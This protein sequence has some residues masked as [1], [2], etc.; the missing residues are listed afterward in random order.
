MFTGFGAFVE[1][2]EY[3][4]GVLLKKFIVERSN[5]YNTQ[6]KAVV[7]G[8]VHYSF[9][10]PWESMSIHFVKGKGSRA[11]DM[12]NNEYLD[13]FGKFGANILGY[14]N[15]RYVESLVSHLNKITAANL[16]D[17]DYGAAQA[18]CDAVPGAE[19]VR[20]SLSGT[21]AVQN[22]IRLARG[23]TKKN[24]F[25]RFSPHFHGNADNIMGGA[26]GD[27]SDPTP[28]TFQNDLYDTE[29]KAEG[30]LQAQSFLLPWNDLELLKEVLHTN[31]DVVAAIITEP[32]CINGG[33]IM[34]L[35]GYLE[36]MR[37]LCDKYGI[38]LIFDEM[39]TGFRVGIGGAQ[40]LLGVTPDITTLGKAMAG[41]ALPVS[42]VAGKKEIMKLYEN[43][44][45]AHGGTFN[46]Y[47]LGLAAVKTTIDILSE[48][49]GVHYDVM[50]EHMRAI[51]S[52]FL[53]AAHEHGIPF[54]IKSPASCAVF[55]L[56]NER[57]SN[58]P[59]QKM[60]NQYL[61]KF[62]GQSLVEY[63][64]LHSNSNRFYGNISLT[65]ADVDLFSD[66]I[67]YV[68]DSVRQFIDR[69]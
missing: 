62:V 66:R 27:S 3:K 33:G 64:I 68:F 6:L 24:R 29:G 23:Y 41:G 25:I 31:H 4:G 20:F 2:K 65:K 17:V 5:Q 18:I 21:E 42:A 1:T 40:K 14:N 19:R 28:V 69:I 30:I 32:I 46:G 16:S 58:D 45:V 22:A 7:P 57:N 26:P 53:S 67:K 48:N 56:A 9:R 10:I 35:P 13:L 15:E 63:G 43:R 55:S 54:E 59:K 38:V 11:W 49:N 47:T 39:I 12:D 60:I 61:N 34:P 8:G 44:K 36:G 51:C 37:E 50:N 52:A